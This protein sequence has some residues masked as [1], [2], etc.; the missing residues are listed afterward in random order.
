VRPSLLSDDT[1]SRACGWTSL[2]E[3]SMRACVCCIP[4]VLAPR[5][6]LLPLGGRGDPASVVRC[7]LVASAALIDPC[8][9]QSFHHL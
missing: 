5:F 3:I 6:S 1:K 2:S 9:L 7:S 4:K 8:T